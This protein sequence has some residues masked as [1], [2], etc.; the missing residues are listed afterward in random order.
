M[1]EA[2]EEVPLH[3]V[4]LRREG[5]MLDSVDIYSSSCERGLWH[6]ERRTFLGEMGFS[7][8]RVQQNLSATSKQSK[9]HYVACYCY[10]FL[11]LRFTLTACLDPVGPRSEFL[12]V[13]SAGSQFP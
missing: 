6:F 4:D 3:P 8:L 2:L 12:S 5:L 1:V 13:S 7:S 9:T 10:L 11:N